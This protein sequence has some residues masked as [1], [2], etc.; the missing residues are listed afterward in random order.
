MALLKRHFCGS[1]TQFDDT[2]IREYGLWIYPDGR[3]PSPGCHKYTTSSSCWLGTLS[4]ELWW[5]SPPGAW[6]LY[7]SAQL[8][9][10][11]K[12]PKTTCT[13]SRAEGLVGRGKVS[14][15]IVAE[16]GTW[17]IVAAKGSSQLEKIEPIF[18]KRISYSLF[19]ESM[20]SILGSV[21]RSVTKLERLE[22]GQEDQQN[23]LKRR[24]PTGV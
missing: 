1:W 14:S 18:Y 20:H 21:T 2:A 22:L 7:C 9:G 19:I 11:A 4:S 5:E 16:W 23:L 13:I 15:W 8:A 6:S 12:T 24:V 3:S 10:S 17:S